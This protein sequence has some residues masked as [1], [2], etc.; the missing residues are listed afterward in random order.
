MVI[1]LTAYSRALIRAAALKQGTTVTY[2]ERTGF[3]F[4]SLQDE[5]NFWYACV[6]KR[7]PPYHWLQPSLKE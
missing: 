5:A 7:L 2:D 4:A 6:C 1:S 3:M